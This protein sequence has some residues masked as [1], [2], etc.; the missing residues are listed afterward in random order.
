MKA[1]EDI[2]DGGDG[3]IQSEREI[4]DMPQNFKQWLADNEQRIANANKNGTL[5]YFL[6]DNGKVT[7]IGFRHYTTKQRLI[8]QREKEYQQLKL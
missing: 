3:T 2:L 5:P 1:I 4:T 8:S 7:K 6:K